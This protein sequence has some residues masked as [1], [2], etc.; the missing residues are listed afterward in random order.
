[1]RQVV[2]LKLSLSRPVRM[3][4]STNPGLFLIETYLYRAA[5]STS[6][7]LN[8][9]NGVWEGEERDGGE[10]NDMDLHVQTKPLRRVCACVCVCVYV[11]GFACLCCGC[12]SVIG[13]L[14]E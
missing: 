12:C 7:S 13:H 3:H 9:K 2:D 10:I 6:H 1:M 4:V 5:K 8:M 14:N 11:R